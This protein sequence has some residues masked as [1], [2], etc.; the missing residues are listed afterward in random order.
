M[1]FTWNAALS[2]I[3]FLI[4][5]A[6][7]MDLF[8]SSA[9]ILWRQSDVETDQ[10]GHKTHWISLDHMFTKHLRPGPKKCPDYPRLSEAPRSWCQSRP[11]QGR[12]PPLANLSRLDHSHSDVPYWDSLEKYG[13]SL[14]ILVSTFLGN[15]LEH[16]FLAPTN[17]HNI[18]IGW[19]SKNQ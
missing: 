19:Y 1:I 8:P 14:K 17:F 11:H 5:A 10:K 7:E 4:F 2:W 3:T 15:Q 9:S 18:D 13:R 12:P 16:F 6:L